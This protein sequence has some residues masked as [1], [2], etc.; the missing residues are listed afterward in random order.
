MKKLAAALVVVLGIV[1]VVGFVFRDDLTFADNSS[2]PSTARD[3]GPRPGAAAAGE[4]L[5]GLTAGELALFD[6]GKK[7]FEEAENVADGLGPTMNLGSCAGCHAQPAV[8]G[9]SPAQNVQVTFATEEGAT[10][11]VPPF[12]TP[13]GPVREVRFVRTPDGTQD[14]GV[15]DLFTITGRADAPGCKLAQPDFATE[16]AR[17][18]V[19]FRIPTPVFGLGLVEEIPDSAILANRASDASRKAEMRIGGRPN[20][21]LAGHAISGQAN[22]NGN[23]GTIARFGWK[24]QNKSL[25]LFSGEAYNVEMGITNELFQT[26]RDETPT[27]QFATLPND[28]TKTDAAG[29]DVLGA[30]EKF[31][32]FSRFL[33]PPR[34]SPDTPGGAASISR[35]RQVFAET[36]CALCHTPTLTTGNAAVAALREQPVNLYSDLL[37]HDMGPGLGDGISQGQAG[38]REFRTAPLWGLGQRLFLLHDGRTTDLKEAIR[39]HR[40]GH[41]FKASEANR[42]VRN[43][44]ALPDDAQQD[45]LNFLR[46]L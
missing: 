1:V 14:G 8:G 32:A 43:Y 46:S 20:I 30:I 23:D 15:H 42:V 36:G 12:I 31:A 3:P 17:S 35:G 10:N 13:T 40:S 27:C 26:E 11:K 44:N 9:T 22:K 5:A 18:N 7:E 21:V 6:A 38:P 28:V 39:A 33:A 24:A 41:L 4:P 34:P 29:L 16:L 37:V 2:S 45:L 25:L 19:I